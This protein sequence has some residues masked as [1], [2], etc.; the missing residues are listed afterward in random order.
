MKWIDYIGHDLGIEGQWLRD[1]GKTVFCQCPNCESLFV[2]N[3]MSDW[4]YCPKCGVTVDTA[5][6]PQTDIPKST[7]RTDCTGCRFVGS[8]DT[9]FPCANCVRKNK[10]YY[11]TPQTEREGE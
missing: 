8:Y 5:D 3:F 1:D 6:T 2:R 7:L 10:D 4:K 11:D 9:E